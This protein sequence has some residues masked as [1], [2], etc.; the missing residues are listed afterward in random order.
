MPLRQRRVGS[1]RLLVEL[2]VRPLVVVLDRGVAAVGPRELGRVHA[3]PRLALAEALLLGVGDDVDELRVRQRA[4]E[5]VRRVVQRLA[6]LL[7]M[8]R[9]V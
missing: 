9:K 7:E 1:P 5:E 4:P 3:A 8:P 2:L 6:L